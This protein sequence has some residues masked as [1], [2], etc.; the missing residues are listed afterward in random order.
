MKS[1]VA[2]IE[3]RLKELGADAYD[4]KLPE[5]RTLP[6]VLQP[7]EQI[8]GVVYG[9]YQLEND[10]SVGRGVL[11]ATDKRIML[12]DKKPM[13]VRND[14]IAYETVNGITYTRVNFGST[15]TLHAREGDI[16]IR[17]F[18]QKCARSFVRAIEQDIFNRSKGRT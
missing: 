1:Q 4:M 17:T 13:F 9:R 14:D 10:M 16:T 5:T 15:I 12:L 18:N 3:K 6:L 11:L 8:I 2:M 7:A